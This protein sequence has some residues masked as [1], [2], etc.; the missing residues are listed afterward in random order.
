MNRNPLIFDTDGGIDDAQA[1]VMLL[2]HDVVPAAVT[3]VF[4]NVPLDLATRNM[5]AVLALCGADVPVIA[6]QGAPLCQEMV[7]ATHVHGE[8]GLGGA[9]I[10]ADLPPPAGTDAVTFLRDSIRATAATGG[11]TD[12]LMIGPLTNLALALR[13]EPALAAG[14]GQLTIM[15]GTLHGRGNTTP[16]AEFNIFADPE[17]ADIVF[18]TDIPT[19][20]VPWEPCTTH[21]IPGLEMD[22]LF[23]GHDDGPLGHFNKA[24][25]DRSR[26]VV[27]HYG[28][29]DEFR[30]IDPFAAA[31][32]IDPT[33]VLSEVGASVAVAT[34]PGLT[35]GMT[36]VDPSGRLG[37]PPVSLVETGD[38]KRLAELYAASIRW[39]PERQQQPEPTG[40]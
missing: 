27:Q 7:N 2:A 24:I 29:P 35:R 14:I 31:V 30:F 23:A 10:P 17:A 6:G 19:R 28:G 11:R 38:A 13:L 39:R 40:V 15:G 8:D 22:T 21:V 9:P 20:V 37:A 33:L 3:T 36:V 32:V 16:A 1:L 4:G 34:A 26:N 5:L 12:L 25:A 18:A